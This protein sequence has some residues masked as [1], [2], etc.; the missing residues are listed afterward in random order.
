M[1]SSSSYSSCY[2]NYLQ[3]AAPSLSQSTIDQVNILIESTSWEY[4]ETSTDWNNIGVIALIEAEQANELEMR[5]VYL[6]MAADA[7]SKGI[8]ENPLCVAHLALIYNLTGD[9][10]EAQNLA[11]TTFVEDLPLTHHISESFHLGLIYLPLTE[12]GLDKKQFEQFQK[13]LESKSSYIQAITLLSEVLCQAQLVF[14]NPMGLR[15]LHLACQLL[16]FSAWVNLKL[17]IS[18]L[19]NKQQEGLLYIHK[20][21]Q[22]ATDNLKLKAYQTLYLAY[23]DLKKPEIAEFWMMAAR[24]FKHINLTEGKWSE[25]EA[26]SL[27]TYVPFD[28]N[29]LLAVEPTL[30]SIVTSVLIA[31]DDWF[32]KE[33]ELWRNWIKPGMTVID[34]GANVGVYTFSAAHRVGKNGNVLAIEPFSGCVRCLE[35]TRKINDLSWVQI[36][37][38]A[39]SNH[40]GTAQ[41]LLHSAS[42]LNE[43]TFDCQDKM[44]SGSFEEVPCFSLDRLVEQNN[45]TQ[46]DFIKLD[47]EGHEIQVLLG[48]E[49]LLRKFS[50]T[51][52]Y[53]NIS[54]SKGNNL[55]V[56]DFLKSNSY[57]I[58][59]YQPYIQQLIP[60]ENPQD[61]ASELN[62]IAIPLS[63]N[64]S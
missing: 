36:H 46:V 45:L 15:L 52:L 30:K 32:E 10:K 26:N 20:A 2:L 11:F 28:T 51:I 35:E 53:E 16:P 29:I 13:I 37:R 63:K 7:F 27:F 8:D 4:P 43:L 38:G 39:A 21:T 14:Y 47:A 19:M 58:F 31:E 3:T 42:E 24:D 55:S 5:A 49:E 34:V 59:R 57:K 48:A 25:L 23:R 62:L 33:M 44:Q 22:L 9:T 41:L 1:N 40:N 56:Y 50:P 12:K 61:L 60:I 6:E 54:G 18:S 64:L 17:G